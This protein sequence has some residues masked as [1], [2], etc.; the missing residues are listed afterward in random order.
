MLFNTVKRKSC[1]DWKTFSKW[2]KRK[3]LKITLHCNMTVVF[4][5]IVNITYRTSLW[6]QLDK[7]TSSTE[8]KLLFQHTQNIHALSVTKALNDISFANYF[9]EFFV[10]TVSG[11]FPHE[12]I[13]TLCIYPNFFWMLVSEVFL[14]SC[15]VT[16]EVEVLLG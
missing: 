3:P 5:G 2:E 8:F 6:R 13:Y 11:C 4:S 12:K 16:I 1:T 9:E 15:C 10:V 14:L 7:L